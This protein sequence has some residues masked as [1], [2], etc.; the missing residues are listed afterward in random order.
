M[1]LLLAIKFTYHWFSNESVCYIIL[2]A[3][4][5]PRPRLERSTC[6]VQASPECQETTD[7]SPS[8]PRTVYT[9]SVT[10]PTS[11]AARQATLDPAATSVSFLSFIVSSG[12]CGNLSLL[13]RCFFGKRCT[14]CCSVKKSVVQDT[15]ALVWY[16]LVVVYC[17]MHWICRAVYIYFCNCS[18]SYIC[19]INAIELGLIKMDKQNWITTIDTSDFFCEK[20]GQ[21]MTHTSSMVNV[22]E[23]VNVEWCRTNK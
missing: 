4:Y 3:Y 14:N 8:A 12:I 22:N 17:T 1:V 7:V 6:V 23:T 10:S 15:C 18:S 5:R 19:Y 9:A 2:Y 21:P 20:R 13:V 11:A 16:D